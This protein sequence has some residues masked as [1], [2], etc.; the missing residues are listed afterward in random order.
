MC[1]YTGCIYI[2]EMD[3]AKVN[4]DW[5][6]SY[7]SVYIYTQINCT[8]MYRDLHKFQACMYMYTDKQLHK[9]LHIHVY[10]TYTYVNVC[11]VLH[12]LYT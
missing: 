8:N 9:Q 5:S 2:K 12:D 1:T 11:A 10:I 3:L 4:S 6:S 7:S